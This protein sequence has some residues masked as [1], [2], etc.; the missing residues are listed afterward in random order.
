MLDPPGTMRT[1]L[2]GV[3]CFTGKVELSKK[4]WRVASIDISTTPPMR[5]P[6]RMPFLTQPFTRIGMH[7]APH[8]K[9]IGKLGLLLGPAVVQ[10]LHQRIVA[11]AQ[12]EK[13]IRGRKLRV[14]TTVVETNIHY[15]TDSA[16]LGDGV[17]VLTRI[18]RQI[19]EV[20]GDMG[21]KVRDR[22][23]SVGH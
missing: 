23:R 9:T 5:K 10:Q 19:T 8:A 13:V 11:Q 12:A 20:A 2:W 14:D 21:E 22:Q 6:S 16:M 7:Q 15:P 3:N 4:G 18:M 1:P 17:R